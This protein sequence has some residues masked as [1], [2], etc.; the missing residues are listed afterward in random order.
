M[1]KI[2][3]KNRKYLTSNAKK[4]AQDFFEN[5]DLS[6]ASDVANL[7][8]KKFSIT[9]EGRNR[10]LFH[11]AFFYNEDG[12][13]KMGYEDGSAMWHDSIKDIRYFFDDSCVYIAF[14]EMMN[15]FYEF[16]EELNKRIE[17]KESQIAEFLTFIEDYKNMQEHKEQI[18]DFYKN[19][20]EI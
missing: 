14:T 7:S 5:F 3:L 16:I 19:N 2:E 1:K 11:K 4:I 20:E 15:V 6:S 13:L 8:S 10:E 18:N 9:F 12:V 17:T